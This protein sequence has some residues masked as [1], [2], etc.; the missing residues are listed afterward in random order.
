M[1][2]KTV[3][4]VTALFSPMTGSSRLRPIFLGINNHGYLLAP[5]CR[6]PRAFVFRVIDVCS[7]NLK[8]Q[9]RK[10]PGRR[11]TQITVSN[12]PLTDIHKM[13]PPSAR[14]QVMF[15]CN[16]P[17]KLP[18]RRPSGV[19]E[20]LS[21]DHGSGRTMVLKDRTARSKVSDGNRAL[22]P[23]RNLLPHA[24]EKVRTTAPDF[25]CRHGFIV[26]TGS[27]LKSSSRRKRSS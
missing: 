23:W 22:V 7:R 16:I 20:Q 18:L 24:V 6:L 14:F 10:L 26:K 2:P 4:A 19:P 17:W 1:K 12:S 5:L 25:L 21:Q 11:R 9:P 13:M 27:G 3:P 8:P 15:R